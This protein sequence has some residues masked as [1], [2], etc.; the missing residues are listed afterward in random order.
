MPNP[1]QT[2]D[3][4]IEPRWLVPVNPAGEVLEA[5]S[6]AIH[7]GRVAGIAPR[8]QAR[9]QWHPTE[10]VSLPGHAIMPGLVNAHT[11]T[12]M[13][14][15]RGLADDLPLMEWL[16]N[17]IWP[18]EGRLISPQFVEDGAYL[19]IAEML[20]GGT[21]CFQDM[22]FFPDA[23]ARAAV[24]AGIRA[25]IGLILIDFPTAWAADP[26][27]Y[28]AK[29]RQLHD[30]YRG[31][32]LITTAFAPHAPYT[33]SDEPL[34]RLRVLADELDLPIQMHV[35]ETAF[36]VS[37][38]VKED[39]KRPLARLDALNLLT[40]GFMAVHM[41]QL[42]QEEIESCAQTGLSVV[43]CPESNLK[44]ASGFC[45]VAKLQDA[46]IN[47]A[48]GTDGAASNNDLDMFGELRTAA[49]LAKAVANDASQLPAPA[50]L[51]MATL[52][53]AKALGLDAHIGSLEH[54]KWADICAIEL[55]ALEAQPVYD[56]IS[57]LVYT[58][59]RHQVSD[60]WVAGR[61]LLADHTLTT[62]DSARIAA[63]ARGWGTRIMEVSNHE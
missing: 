12:A 10:T 7:Q 50:A 60:V 45:P 63:H 46:G 30:D 53:G 52:G 33:V 35:H 14:L 41:T 26:A 62:L 43:H 59:D 39:G 42:E 61:R 8:E 55:D 38:A 44:L 31:H 54:G 40:P 6:L 51:H 57:Q 49:L 20:R 47:L 16:E 17:H 37:Q 5:H 11:H 29:G 58:T 22:Y 24:Q 32:P 13:S 9:D 4:L 15:M 27:E 34:E 23:V 3:T 48:L 19:A 18:V 21:T 25:S 2:I 28:L 56:V 1:A 36:E